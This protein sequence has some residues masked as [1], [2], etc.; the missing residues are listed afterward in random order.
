VTDLER[1][2]R[3]RYPVKSL[4]NANLGSTNIVSSSS[5]RYDALGTG[6]KSTQEIP[7]DWSKFENHTFFHSAKAKV[8]E[9]FYRI[10]NEY[11]FDGAQKDI[12]SF[13]DS[14]TGFEGYVLSRF[15]YNKG[16]LHLSGN[17]ISVQNRSGYLFE[18]SRD[19]SSNPVLDPPEGSFTVQTHL[20]LPNESNDNEVVFQRQNS[21][22][23]YTLFVSMS[24]SATAGVHFLVTSGSKVLHISG[25]ILKNQFVHLAAEVSSSGY[26]SFASLLFNGVPVADQQ[27]LTDFKPITLGSSQLTIGSGSTHTSP[28]YQFVPKT[29]LSGCL[30]DFRFYTKSRDP[31]EIS[32][33]YLSTPFLDPRLVLHFKFNEPTGS[34]SGNDIVLD[35]SGKSLH[36]QIENY[37]TA[38]RGLSSPLNPMLQEDINDCVVLFSNYPDIQSFHASILDEAES[39]DSENP[40]IITNLIPQ[41]YLTAGAS[42]QGFNSGLQN[43]GQPLDLDRL[44]GGEMQDQP[45][46]I[47]G[48]LFIYAKLFDEIKIF[49]DHV[50]NLMNFD[51]TKSENIADKM[52]PF[53]ARAMKIDL[54]DLFSTPSVNRLVKGVAISD[55]YVKV[56]LS[57][58][59]LRAQIWRRILSEHQGIMM[60]K[61]TH[62]SIRSAFAA[63][64]IEPDSFFHIR[65]FG[66]N[67]GRTIVDLRHR[68]NKVSFFADFSGSINSSPSAVDSLGF[69]SNIPHAIS[70]FLSGSRIEPGAPRIAGS[71]VSSGGQR[72]SNNR[73]DGLWTSGSF[74]LESRVRFLPSVGHPLT[75]SIIRLCTTGSS[76]PA[77]A[78][79]VV[80]NLMAFGGTNPYF[81]LSARPVQ[82]VSA[83]VKRLR[84]ETNPFDGGIWSLSFGRGTGERL[85]TE[86]DEL[87]LRVSRQVGGVVT[88][89]SASSVT[90]VPDALDVLQNSSDSYN[91]SGSFIVIGSQSLGPS[92][93]FLNSDTKASYT[94]FTGQISNIRFWSNY[95]DLN[96]WIDHTRDFESLGVRDP[97]KNFN[98]ESNLS[99]SFER[100][101]LDVSLSQASL[102]ASILGNFTGFDFSQNSKHLQMTGFEADER[103]IFPVGETVMSPSPFF[104]LLENDQKTRVRSL[105]NPG[106][107][108]IAALPAPVYQLPENEEVLDDNRLSIEYSY[109]ANLN[110]DIMKATSNLDFF[111]DALGRPNSYFENFYSDLD[112]FSRVYFNRLTSDIDLDRFSRL[113][114]W[115]DGSLEVLIS[116]LIPAKTY[117]YGINQVIEP[118]SLERSRQRFFFDDMYLNEG[119]RFVTRNLLLYSLFGR[120]RGF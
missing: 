33:D 5:F 50:S 64:G 94:D 44:R 80:F 76:S 24:T 104:D 35:F 52:I 115:L 45:Q 112:D 108:E 16:Y 98:F 100:L 84:V 15:P 36:S 19:D 67:K 14:L 8:D 85:E 43:V 73:S 93:L 116:Q 40:N 71:F 70:G 20:F 107:D 119:E 27:R 51:Y 25:S 92:S 28:G 111:D 42:T 6:L 69:S 4:S 102:T 1:N 47:L 12:E 117:F 41:Q 13:E 101:R 9:A 114:R 105:Q 7:L 62:R 57:L 120:F 53:I 72:L 49:V 23:G 60:S 2:L 81:E 89:S 82:S 74:T 75:Q 56:G 26:E 55:D 17:Y 38:S 91:A 61:G 65:E 68:R 83:E 90:F 109:S 86:L 66:A 39:Y 99:G 78:Q 106:P 29:T 11:P 34:F 22:G 59:K 113:Y 118:H 21:D 46:P 88:F 110:R 31:S 97:R 95:I 10:I 58:K 37:T 96:E 30:D 63:M 103:V 48:L 77:S 18:N 54:P 79:A 32:L 3:S 87:F